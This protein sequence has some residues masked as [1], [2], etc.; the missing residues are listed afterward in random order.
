MADQVSA[1]VRSAMMARVKGRNTKPELAVRSALFADGFR[2]RLHRADLP[3][4]PDIILPRYRQA[5]FVHGCFWHSHDCPKG[6]QRP[7]SNVVFW[8]K[9]LDGNAE[10]DQRNY[11]ALMAAGWDVLVIWECQ[12]DLGIH[13]LLERLHGVRQRT[14]RSE[15]TEPTR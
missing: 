9:K 7:S 4:R 13:G 6:R 11:A 2:F 8:A 10:R 1:G 15:F 5:V 3:G 14:R 12:L